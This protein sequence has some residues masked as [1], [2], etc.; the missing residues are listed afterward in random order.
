MSILI[1][2]GHIVDPSQGIDKKGDILISEGKVARIGGT[3]NTKAETTIDA[4]GKIVSPGFVDMHTHLRE[5]GDEEAETIETALSAAAKGGFTTVSAM[6]NTHPA[7]DSQ[8]HVKFL[9]EKAAEAGLGNVLPIGT[10]TKKREGEEMSEMQELKD[11]G[12][13][14]ISDDGSSVADPSLMKKAME[15][16][17]MVDIVVISHAEDKDLVAGGV[18]RE[19]Y[20]ST[21]LGLR[22]I[23]AEAESTIVDRDVRLAEL[24]GARLHIAHVSAKESVEIIRQAK[25][26]EVNVTAEVTPHHFTLTDEDAKGYDTNMKVNPPLALAEDI[27]ALKKGLKDGTI[28]VIATDHAPHSANEKEKEFN[29]AP[30]G[31]IG[32]E[33]AL[34]LSV[35]NLIDKGILTW[36]ELIEKIALNPSDILG[37]E[38]G[39][40]KEGAIADITIIDPKAEWTYTEEEIKSKSKNSPFIGW[41]L[42]GKV[43]D[44]IAE[45]KIVLSG[46]K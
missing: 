42:K 3:I 21:V 1:K 35:M 44:V 28:D 37:Y 2:N 46:V 45:G 11:A 19:G 33:T 32:L 10:I 34:S 7:C 40:L 20:F 30:F 39:T 43:T 38:G 27:E 22:P 24:T 9:Q 5:P 26:R 13:Y 17:S 4:S 6:P 8:A 31:M 29:Y 15:Y 41:K 36:P 12:A 16:A 18:M 14:A 23:P 25:K